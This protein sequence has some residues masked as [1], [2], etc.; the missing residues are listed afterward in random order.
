VHSAAFPGGEIRGQIGPAATPSVVDPRLSIQERYTNLWGYY[1]G[2]TQNAQDL[3]NQRFL[4]PE[5]ANRLTNQALNDMLRTGLLPKR[6]DFLPG[7]AP[8][9]LLIDESEYLR[10]LKYLQEV[11]TETAAPMVMDHTAHGGRVAH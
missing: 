8:K 5:D 11:S 6:G 4:L 7:F 9:R 2:V 3:V 10:V 1:Y